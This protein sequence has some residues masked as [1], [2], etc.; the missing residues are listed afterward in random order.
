MIAYGCIYCRTGNEDEF[1]ENIRK[2]YPHIEPL[3]VCKMQILRKQ[4]GVV[5]EKAAVLFPGYVF[6]RMED[7]AVPLNGQTPYPT[8]FQQIFKWSDTFRLLT[9]VGGDWRLVGDDLALVQKLYNE[10][11]TIGFSKVYFDEGNRVRVLE[12][13][14]KDYEGDI[15]RVDRR[16]RSAQIRV[17]FNGK[18]VTMWLGYEVIENDSR[19]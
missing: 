7:S 6:F 19:C 12:G 14:L 1:A 4:G 15:I 11:G 3:V 17:D 16:H 2:T 5:E 9:N 13:F 10:G 18:S 8:E